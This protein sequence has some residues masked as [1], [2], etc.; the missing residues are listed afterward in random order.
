MYATLL[1]CFH[2]PRP[3]HLFRN[4]SITPFIKMAV[5]KAKQ[6]EAYLDKGI[7]VVDKR[8][9]YYHKKKVLQVY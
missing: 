3:I 1:Y 9:I 5:K 8:S 6:T 4:S 7:V 2:T